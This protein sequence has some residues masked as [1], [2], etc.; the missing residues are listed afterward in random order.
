MKKQETNQTDLKTPKSIADQDPTNSTSQSSLRPSITTSNEISITDDTLSSIDVDGSDDEVI[1]LDVLSER[2]RFLNL[3]KIIIRYK[4]IEIS[5]IIFWGIVT[6]IALSARIFLS[7]AD[8]L[9]EPIFNSSWKS[10]ETYCN[11]TA[12]VDNN[13]YT[14]I[15]S[16]ILFLIVPIFLTVDCFVSLIKYFR[17]RRENKEKGIKTENFLVYHFYETD[18]FVY[19]SESLLRFIF[20]VIALI[21]YLVLSSTINT[22][23]TVGGTISSL[24]ITILLHFFGGTFSNPGVTIYKTYHNFIR[25]KKKS[26]NALMPSQQ[27][28][29]LQELMSSPVSSFSIDYV[30]S[31]RVEREFFH[32]FLK[33][34]FSVENLLFAEDLQKLRNINERH[35]RSKVS[36]VKEMVK[37]YLSDNS[38]VFEVNIPSKIIHAELKDF[39]ELT[40]LMNQHGIQLN[41]IPKSIKEKSSTRYFPQIDSTIEDQV[42]KLIENLSKS[43]V[44][45]TLNIEIY[46]NLMDSFYRFKHSRKWIEFVKTNKVQI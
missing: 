38:S 43:D 19:R 31:R 20:D 26:K 22:D 45:S 46:K 40:Q 44:F 13:L 14:L 23:G 42:R 37:L 36:K 8:T 17:L 15:I 10:L 35:A 28:Q 34:E 29:N 39:R 6:Y 24:V 32:E 11:Y 30:I 3:L 41:S 21:I 27:I 2:G 1:S 18:P 9:I 7:P 16:A 4:V 5:Y 12:R 33:K 25:M